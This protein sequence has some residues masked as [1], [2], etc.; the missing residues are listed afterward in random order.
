MTA[1]VAGDDAEVPPGVQPE[2]TALAWQRTGLALAVGALG[3]GRLLEP[4]L[5]PGV[6]LLAAAGAG[7]AGLL[8]RA[9]RRRAVRWQ[10]VLDDEDRQ[11][12]AR[13]GP[14]GRLLAGTAAGVL[15]LGAAALLLVVTS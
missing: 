4:L 14:D 9:G 2:R 13:P 10:A 12:V 3:G 15:L 7:A 6:W 5:G 8:V 1:P 11:A